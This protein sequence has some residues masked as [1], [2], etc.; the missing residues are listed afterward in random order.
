METVD[1]D[2]LRD[3]IANGDREKAKE[4]LYEYTHCLGNITMTGYNSTLSNLGFIKKRDRQDKQGNFVG[5][6]N[7]LSINADIAEK[8][9]WTI[10]DIKERTNKLVSQLLI[11]FKI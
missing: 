11:L 7:G 5:Y 6:K 10:E 4:Y 2:K 3:M 8:E 9:K 1:F